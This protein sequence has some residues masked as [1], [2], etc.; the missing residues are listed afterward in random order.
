MWLLHILQAYFD[1]LYFAVYAFLQ[2]EELWQ[3]YIKEIYQCQFSNG[4]CSLSVLISHFVNSHNTSNFFIVISGTVICLQES[5]M[6][7]L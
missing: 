4:M 7:L 6:L 5:L 1:L 3:P 2:I